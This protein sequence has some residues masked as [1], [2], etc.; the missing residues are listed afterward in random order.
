M[1]G[2]TAGIGAGTLVPFISQLSGNQPL[3]IGACYSI[4]TWFLMLLLPK[5][6][7]YLPKVTQV[8]ELASEQKSNN[9]VSKLD[10]SLTKA[11]VINEFRDARLAPLESFAI[12]P[13]SFKE[14]YMDKKLNVTRPRIR[15]EDEDN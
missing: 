10:V 1:I 13:F 14:S 12:H 4:F 6:G 5:P 9:E 7:A 15:P 2:Q 3:M 8:E 11:S